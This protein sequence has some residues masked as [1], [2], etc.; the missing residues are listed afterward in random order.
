MKRSDFMKI[1]S[2]AVR[3]LMTLDDNKPAEKW[4]ELFTTG[5]R[6]DLERIKNEQPVVKEMK[7]GSSVRRSRKS[8]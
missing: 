7:K 3:D 5:M 2:K 8:K 4:E 6:N 1:V